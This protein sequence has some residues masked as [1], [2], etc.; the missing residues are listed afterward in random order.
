MGV[1]P[2]AQGF[3]DE[4]FSLAVGL[5]RVG[6]GA[7]VLQAMVGAGVAELMGL[8]AGAVVGH[9]AAD[10]HAEAGVVGERRLQEGDGVF[11]FLVRHDFAKGHSGIVV[12]ADM[13]EFPAYAPAVA[14]VGA[15][16]SDAKYGRPGK[17]QG[18]RDLVS[19]S[20]LGA[21]GAAPQSARQWGQVIVRMHTPIAVCPSSSTRRTR[22]T[23]PAGLS[24]AFLWT[25]IRFPPG[26]FCQEARTL[27]D[28][29]RRQRLMAPQ[30]Q[31]PRRH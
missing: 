8:V 22:I 26:P 1:G 29:H 7:D 16:A 31:R 4:A 21:G 5:R 20:A 14:L 24:R 2:F 28:G 18:R 13:D 17:R 23:R 6:L 3:L 11:L 9:D 15:V 27:P 12:D 19:R 30:H 10:G 25:S